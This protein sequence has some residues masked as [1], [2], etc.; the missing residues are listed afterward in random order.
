MDIIIYQVCGFSQ[1]VGTRQGLDLF[2]HNKEVLVAL[3]VARRRLSVYAQFPLTVVHKW[4]IYMYMQKNNK[5]IQLSR[6]GIGCWA[7]GGG[8]YWGDQNQKDVDAVVHAALEKGLN[9]FD[10][11]RMYN[12]GASE[13]SLGKALRGLRDRAF[14]ISKVSPA[15]AYR[16]SLREECEISLRSLGTDYLDMYMMHWPINPPGIKHFTD[17]PEIIANPPTTEE[18]FA[19]L[20][21]L[22][23]EGKIRHIGVSN[24]GIKQLKEAVSFCAEIAVNEMPYSI[25]SRAIEAEIMPYCAAQGIRIISSMTLQ[26]GVLAGIYRSVDDVP[27]HQAHSRHFAQ[28]RGKGL[29][30][31]YE[32]GAEEEVFRTVALLRDLS[33]ELGV[34]VAQISVAWVLANPGIACAL[35]GSRSEKELDDNIR[36]MEL[37]LPADA[38][39]R[40]NQTSLGVLQKLGNNPDY[41]ENSKE[42]RIY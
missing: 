8:E 27:P 29:S 5:E 13:V 10:T 26:Q 9:V 22:K 42:S 18:A 28:E 14:V 20:E 17:D 37:K 32:A 30:R 36:A 38:V 39:K 3:A 1:G 2:L 35:V 12:N 11:A 31:H 24:Y 23:K 33:A 34:S 40:I 7:F 16:K 25:I 41:Y 6:I 4:Y 21:E 19:A 15:R